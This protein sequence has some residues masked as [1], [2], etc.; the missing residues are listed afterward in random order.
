ML[1]R[2]ELAALAL[3]V[4]ASPVAACGEGEDWHDLAAFDEL[5]PGEFIRRELVFAADYGDLGRRGIWLGRAGD[6]VLALKDACSHQGC[7]VRYIASSE[8]FICP[9]HG[10]VFGPRGG[11][12]AGPPRRPLHRYATRVRDGRVYV[13]WA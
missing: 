12:L 6:A 13:A 7:P 4:A 3:A 5:V 10:G 1:T 8:R 2:R 11:A 9:C